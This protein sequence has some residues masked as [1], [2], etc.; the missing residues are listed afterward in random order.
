M[1]RIL[2]VVGT[3]GIGLGVLGGA[4]EAAPK[5]YHFELTAVTV[6]SEVKPDVGG[7]A[8]PRVE[9]LVKK[10][11]ETH[12]QLVLA[13]DGAPDPAKPD[14]YR[15]YLKSHGLSGSYLVTVEITDARGDVEPSDKPNTS[16]LVMHIGLHML[17][18]T[19]PEHTMG[20]TGDGQATVKVEVSKNVRDRDRTYAWDQAADLAVADAI[21]TS[22]EQL[23]A[24]KKK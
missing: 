18:E 4:T 13:L 1:T 9:T 14:A 3:V 15:A 19:I 20:F 17:G 23:E 5:K 7:E 16:R 11:F 10:A 21:K 6:R 12:P 2:A 8:Q 22:I 24:P